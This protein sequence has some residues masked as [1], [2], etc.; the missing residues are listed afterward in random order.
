MERG[1]K[2][3]ENWPF[4]GDVWGITLTERDIKDDDDIK[5]YYRGSLFMFRFTGSL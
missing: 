4:K 1:L 5:W 2:M 3:R